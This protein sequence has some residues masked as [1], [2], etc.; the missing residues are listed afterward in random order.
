MD[1]TLRTNAFIGHNEFSKEEE[2]IVS[3]EKESWTQPA[4]SLIVEDKDSLGFGLDETINEETISTVKERASL[5][6]QQTTF[7]PNISPA[8]TFRYDHLASSHILDY[9]RFYTKG[10]V[11]SNITLAPQYPFTSGPSE[12]TFSTSAPIFTSQREFSLRQSF[13]SNATDSQ[14]SFASVSERKVTV[15]FP[16]TDSQISEGIGFQTVGISSDTSQSSV[17]SESILPFEPLVTAQPIS[18][19]TTTT[20]PLLIFT[21]KTPRFG[22]TSTAAVAAST[23]NGNGQSDTSAKRVG[24]DDGSDQS[25]ENELFMTNMQSH[26]TATAIPIPLSTLSKVKP[27]GRAL[28]GTL[29]NRAYLM[30]IGDREILDEQMQELGAWHVPVSHIAVGEQIS[31]MPETHPHENSA[32][33]EPQLALFEEILPS[34]IN[35]QETTAVPGKLAQ[36]AGSDE[37][38]AG[39][40]K[41]A[42]VFSLKNS[43]GEPTQSSLS[44]EDQALFSSL[45]GEQIENNVENQSGAHKS[46]ESSLASSVS[47]K[48]VHPLAVTH[49]T[50]SLPNYLQPINVLSAASQGIVKL[51]GSLDQEDASEELKLT[52]SEDTQIPDAKGTAAIKL[53]AS[54]N[55]STLDKSNNDTPRH[56]VGLE[57]STTLPQSVPSITLKLASSPKSRLIQI[58]DRSELKSTLEKSG[59]TEE[60]DHQHMTSFATIPPSTSPTSE[61]RITSETF[62]DLLSNELYKELEKELNED[63]KEADTSFIATEV[64][65]VLTCFVLRFRKKKA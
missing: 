58:G 52:V 37:F 23:H 28:H 62:G 22:S 38:V 50:T 63:K 44:L 42:I 24:N 54:T 19:I 61:G 55:S 43:A 48:M 18:A 40:N 53:S 21:N 39:D 27:E 36:A 29:P 46:T 57:S 26:L 11:E 59:G 20:A 15:G 7:A 13:R 3:Q 34:I 35:V 9:S 5:S 47:Q 25:T 1:S 4:Q 60:E 45:F 64:L 2:K 56:E 31:E 30:P 14:R 65:F 17:A 6:I 12:H 10:T 33:Q 49:S 51:S 16:S 8:N 41:S 32:E